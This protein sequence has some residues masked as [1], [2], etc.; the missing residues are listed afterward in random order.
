MV[1]K[2]SFTL[3]EISIVMCVVALLIGSLI[4]GRKLVER[5]KIQATIAEIQNYQSAFAKF[6]D[7]Y[8]YMPGDMPDAQAKL[9]PSGYT[10]ATLATIKTLDEKILRTIPLNGHGK[11]YIFNCINDKALGKVEKGP[12]YYS[13]T[14]GAW[15][16][17]SAAGLIEE[18]Y[19]NLC[20]NLTSVNGTD[21]FA[22]GYNLP[23]AKHAKGAYWFVTLIREYDATGN[24]NRRGLLVN[25][26]VY[27][28]TVLELVDT[29]KMSQQTMTQT[30]GVGTYGLRDCYGVSEKKWGAS[31]GGIAASLLAEIDIKID[32]G[33]PLTG[34]V[35]A[36]NPDVGTTHNVNTNHLCVKIA[37]AQYGTYANQI[38]GTIS[39][40]I[41]SNPTSLAAINMYNATDKQ[42]LCIGVF[43]MPQF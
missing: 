18:K 26:E 34:M 33:F 3:V 24:R 42:A 10:T 19:S 5:A 4:G 40:T 9:A 8:G 31:N 35:A 12:P 16:H 17:L 28:H 20:K 36:Q 41:L 23:K 11:G 15:A 1:G 7:T 6:Y 32:D 39:D 27:K 29:T 37:T 14:I 13:D 38:N 25:Q 43:A 30:S 22:P 21:C 2:K